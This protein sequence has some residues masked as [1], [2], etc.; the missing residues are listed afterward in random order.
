[1]H[2]KTYPYHSRC[3]FTKKLEYYQ[4]SWEEK[5]KTVRSSEIFRN[6]T[7]S[8]TTSIVMNI[9]RRIYHLDEIIYEEG[10]ESSMLF[11]IKNGEIELS[12]KARFESNKSCLNTP[13][14][15]ERIVIAQKT[16][17]DCFGEV[18][19]ALEIP[20][21]TRAKCVSST[22]DVYYISKRRLY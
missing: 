21:D 4:R 11:L 2:S 8:F 1:L 22:L 7:R 18:E 9:R 16:H 12:K 10:S 17:S 5:E 19:M 20:R 14:S 6:A 15:T 13:K 3:I